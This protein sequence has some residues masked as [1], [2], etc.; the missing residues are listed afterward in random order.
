MHLVKAKKEGINSIRNYFMP[1]QFSKFLNKLQSI[2]ALSATESL[3]KRN[4]HVRF[5]A[6]VFF[7]VFGM[8]ANR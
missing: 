2:T 4:L 8:Q 6:F 5:D 1:I 3:Q 7:P